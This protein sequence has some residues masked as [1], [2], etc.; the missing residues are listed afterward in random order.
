MCIRDSYTDMQNVTELAYDKLNRKGFAFFVIGNTEYKGVQ[1]NNAQHLQDAMHN[2]GFR[3]LK[4]HK[5]KISNKILTPYRDKSG[6]FTTSS[7]GRKIYA[8]EFI[9]IGKKMKG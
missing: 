3:Y 4:V 1:I 6:K 5:R 9:V 8:E 2:A 7:T